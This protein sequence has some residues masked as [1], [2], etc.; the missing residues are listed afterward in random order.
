MRKFGIVIL[1]F[2]LVFQ[3]NGFSP[4]SALN[5]AC[6]N[7]WKI[8]L[9]PLKI[10]KDFPPFIYPGDNQVPEI[11]QAAFDDYFYFNYPQNT[12]FLNS[13]LY[14]NRSIPGNPKTVAQFSS[15]ELADK[16]SSLGSDVAIYERW[17][18][19]DDGIGFQKVNYYE[20]GANYDTALESVLPAEHFTEDF[21]IRGA[22]FSTSTTSLSRLG[23]FPGKQVRFTFEI[24]VKG[25]EKA[26]IFSTNSVSV[27]TS[28]VK[29]SLGYKK[30]IEIASLYGYQS[31]NFV[32]QEKCAG[33][34]QDT[35]NWYV[36]Q[37]NNFQSIDI[38]GQE[39]RETLP[40]PMGCGSFGFD[41]Q[42]YPG[43]LA[44][45]D[46]DSTGCLSLWSPSSVILKNDVC[47]IGLTLTVPYHRRISGKIEN[48]DV[49]YFRVL[50]AEKVMPRK[51]LRK[52]FTLSLPSQ[53]KVNSTY[54]DVITE[55][56]IKVD[57]QDVTFQK[58]VK[59]GGRYVFGNFLEFTPSNVC[60]VEPRSENEKSL[61]AGV[62]KTRDAGDCTVTLTLEGTENYSPSKLITTYKVLEEPKLIPKIPISKKSIICISGK[63]TK[64]ITSAK[65][66]CPKGY[67]R[68]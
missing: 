60:S 1:S 52:N 25:C 38:Q 6:P 43:S 46:V 58:T 28:G 61:G 45:A 33:F 35:L 64:Y 50:V 63:F 12:Y 31:P 40:I 59:N 44:L 30:V 29:S 39:L 3:I 41:S 48:R 67:K 16:I 11:S 23:L 10:E 20:G 62:L 56:R 51:I 15:Q 2:A 7:S 55:I 32:L 47:K 4:A 24:R 9:A 54:G 26:G 8:E 22:G 34:I 19:S 68:K 5:E 65:P 17:E 18:V 66:V 27:P 57:G 14:R 53:L 21:W 49:G 13:F 42:F 36:S 37:L